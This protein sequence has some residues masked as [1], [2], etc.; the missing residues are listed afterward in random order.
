MESQLSGPHQKIYQRVFQHPMAHNLQW[1]EVWSMLGAIAGA[2]AV[3][4]GKGNLKVT[5]NGQTLVLHRSRGKDLADKKEL[6][7]V[8]HFLERSET[9]APPS[10]KV[11]THLLVV[12]DHREARIYST[13]LRGSVPQRIV[14]YDP[15]G[16]GR[17]L[18]YNQDDSN[19]QRKPE[20]KSFYEAVAKTLHGAQQI[21]MFGAGTGASSAMEHLVAELKRH[22]PDIAQRI[23]GSIVVD[24]HHLTEDELLAKARELFVAA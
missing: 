23:V 13:E 2:D 7:Q 18:H 4:D 11:G 3:E 17:D 22:H 21:L 24:E 10:A 20:Q 5:R 15:F 19:G 14:P 8:R 6:M 9:A 1:R 16:F 12:I